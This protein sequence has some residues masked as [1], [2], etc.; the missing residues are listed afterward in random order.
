MSRVPPVPGA[1]AE[2]PIHLDSDD[3][4]PARIATR[5]N[6]E[7]EMVNRRS[8]P[9]K[10]KAHGSQTGTAEAHSPDVQ[11]DTRSSNFRLP[12]HTKSSPNPVGAA[13]Q[14]TVGTSPEKGSTLSKKRKRLVALSS[15]DNHS[16]HVNDEKIAEAAVTSSI[17]PREPLSSQTSRQIRNQN[18]G[19]KQGSEDT[20]G[21]HD[22]VL[23]A[24]PALDVSDSDIITYKHVTDTLK[25]HHH[26]LRTIHQ[27]FT[28]VSR[29]EIS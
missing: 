29:L 21:T 3:D 6:S 2:Q 10:Q 15:D 27:Y 19:G 20:W 22:S 4:S 9:A 14:P 24:T 28:K 18:L 8:W 1:S 11:D 5:Q 23:G 16:E 12:T 13:S 17:E 25:K 7:A 26:E